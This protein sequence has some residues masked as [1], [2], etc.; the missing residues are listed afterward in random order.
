[1]ARGLHFHVYLPWHGPVC[2]AYRWRTA[3]EIKSISV[4]ILITKEREVEVFIFVL[5]HLKD[6]I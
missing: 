6:E 2:S 5:D 1:M 3:I 4:N